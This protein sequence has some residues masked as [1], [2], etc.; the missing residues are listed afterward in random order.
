LTLTVK[1]SIIAMSLINLRVNSMTQVA[2]L[3]NE[4]IGDPINGPYEGEDYWIDTD[5]TIQVAENNV[6]LAAIIMRRANSSGYFDTKLVK[7]GNKGD[8]IL[9]GFDTMADIEPVYT[10]KIGFKRDT[11]AEVKRDLAGKFCVYLNKKRA[12]RMFSKLSA[13]KAYLKKLD[14][15]LQTDGQEP[16]ALDD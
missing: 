6:K 14:L 8:S 3:L 11:L 2:E 5:G 12:S 9:L 13:V 1:D 16:E 10:A 15:D 4:I 7:V